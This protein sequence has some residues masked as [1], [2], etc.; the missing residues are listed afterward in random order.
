MT[1]DQAVL[2]NGAKPIGRIIKGVGGRY[3][4]RF[5]SCETAAASARGIF[6]KEGLTPAAGD[7]AECEKSGD[8][9]IPWR[10]VRILPR[11]NHL[12]RPPVANLDGLV[13]TVSAAEPAPDFYLV[14]KLLTVCLLNRIEPLICLTKT[15]LDDSPGCLDSYAPT[16]CRI[17]ETAPDSESS[18][19][20]LNNWID[21]R[22]VS[23]AGQS[24][25]GKSTLLNRLF[26]E[27]RM[28]AGDISSKIGRGRHT[29]RHVE[30]F[31]TN[32]GYLADTP[33]FSSLELADLGV[34]GENLVTG[35]P[36]IIAARES[37]RFTGCR[38][39]GELG[40]AVPDSGIHPDRLQRYRFFRQAL[41]SIDPY[42]GK[43]RIRN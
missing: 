43:T 18:L 6:R 16:G 26:G 29:T 8:P 32:G 5:N 22:I 27:E 41:D 37:C 1:T 10:I 12:V 40:C 2:I 34:S 13:V 24:G 14:D 30:L 21:G 17:L 15:D 35:Y 42:S 36:E 23:F 4:V 28:P 20:A 11:R 3:Q 19:Q 9:D 7:L 31:P 39:I 25:V 38:H 33:G